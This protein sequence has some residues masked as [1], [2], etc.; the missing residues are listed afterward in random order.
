MT[1]LCLCAFDQILLTVS[2][3]FQTLLFVTIFQLI[4]ESSGAS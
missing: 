3:T 1:N 4:V 2:R